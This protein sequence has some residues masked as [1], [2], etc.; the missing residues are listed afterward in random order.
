LGDIFQ[1]ENLQFDT[2]HFFYNLFYLLSKFTSRVGQS[3]NKTV[4]LPS[5]AIIWQYMLSKILNVTLKKKCSNLGQDTMIG[6]SRS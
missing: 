2:L 4:I 3:A 1:L 6:N 5:N